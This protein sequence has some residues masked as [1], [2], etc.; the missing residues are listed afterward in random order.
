MSDAEL[1]H[2]LISVFLQA[3]GPLSFAELVTRTGAREGD[4]RRA[5]TGLLSEDLVV[6]GSLTRDAAEEQYCWAARWQEQVGRRSV[7]TRSKLQE[8]VDTQSRDRGIESGAITAFHRFVIDEYVPP[9]DKRFLI[10]FQID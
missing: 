2:N 6:A 8:V 10:F 1:R 4:V 3:G 7:V 5:L 9:A